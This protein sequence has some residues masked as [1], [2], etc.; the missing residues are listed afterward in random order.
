MNF[1]KKASCLALQTPYRA[2]A[3]LIA[4][5]E[6]TLLTKSHPHGIN[7]PNIRKAKNCEEEE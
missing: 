4:H 3:Y 2:Q 7:Q 6:K 1:N 5:F